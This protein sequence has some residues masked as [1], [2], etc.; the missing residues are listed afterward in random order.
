MHAH[1]PSYCQDLVYTRAYTAHEHLKRRAR[2]GLRS[3][4]LQLN[5]WRYT[6]H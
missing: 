3:G 6:I 4:F 5:T 2:M 1:T